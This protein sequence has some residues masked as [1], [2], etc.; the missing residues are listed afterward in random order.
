MSY[1]QIYKHPYIP[2]LL[3]LSF[4]AVSSTYSVNGD[5]KTIDEHGVLHEF[6]PIVLDTIKDA[7]RII[8]S[9]LA[10][11]ARSLAPFEKDVPYTLKEKMTLLNLATWSEENVKN[12]EKI[13]LNEQLRQAL[14]AE[15]SFFQRVFEKNR[16]KGVLNYSNHFLNHLIRRGEAELFFDVCDA[17]SIEPQES[18]VLVAVQEGNLK[19]AE[20]SLNRVIQKMKYHERKDY[21]MKLY[22]EAICRGNLKDLFP[23]FENVDL[24]EI[25]P[26]SI[27]F[28]VDLLKFASRLNKREAV[29]FLIDKVKDHEVG[30]R[31][32]I[33]LG[34]RSSPF[35]L[36]YLFEHTEEKYLE[37]EVLPSIKLGSFKT[38]ALEETNTSI[39]RLD[40][41]LNEEIKTG[42]SIKSVNDR[43]KELLQK[44]EK[45]EGSLGDH[46]KILELF[47]ASKEWKKL[48]PWM[49]HKRKALLEK[50]KAKTNFERNDSIHDFLSD[51]LYQAVRI[52][53]FETVR[54]CLLSL[55]TY[56]LL[57]SSTYNTYKMDIRENDFI[58]QNEKAIKLA[59]DHGKRDIMQLFMK[60]MDELLA[61]NSSYFP[62]YLSIHSF[63]WSASRKG[64][65]E[66]IEDLIK[67]LH[68]SEVESALTS[69]LK[70]AATA[71]QSKTVKFLHEK[72][73]DLHDHFAPSKLEI[74]EVS[75]NQKLTTLDLACIAGN[76]ELYDFLKS[77]GVGHHLLFF[78]KLG[79]L[80]KAG[81]AYLMK[82]LLE[83]NTSDK[84]NTIDN[85]LM[86][87]KKTALALAVEKGHFNVVKLLIKHGADPTN[88]P[89]EIK[90]N[91][92]FILAAGQENADPMNYPQEIKANAPFVLAADQE[93]LKILRFL[94]SSSK[95]EIDIS[96]VQEAMKRSIMHNR[97]PNL[98]FLYQKFQDRI[99]PNSL[100]ELLITS[101]AYTT[102]LSI[103]NFLIKQG[104]NV[105]ILDK[106][107]N[108][109]LHIAIQG[110][111]KRPTDGR[112]LRKAAILAYLLARGLNI[113]DQNEAK[114]TPLQIAYHKFRYC[115]IDNRIVIALLLQAGADSKKLLADSVVDEKDAENAS[116]LLEKF[117]FKKSEKID[118]IGLP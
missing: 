113:E 42:G 63:L 71:G 110:D 84:K 104:A 80:A 105:K 88:Y 61:K 37:Y 29:R 65:T 49:E 68:T 72:G 107:N 112:E 32:I 53:S 15:F 73:V 95:K 10:E 40:L 23:V 93:N 33:D 115:S 11:S 20:F 7:S 92:P 117:G 89:Q 35:I 30:R 57:S 108:T 58:K 90:A 111:D 4:V 74:L 78:E 59:R 103:I 46:K 94:Y 54:F 36:E 2:P 109:L 18:H 76:R 43:L 77:Q 55:A 83:E 66:I 106:E 22:E 79:F 16:A 14:R 100:S 99:D 27:S 34:K 47:L 13:C 28:L 67:T 6:D 45:K 116:M 1:P 56:N 82:C 19:I 91:V 3:A 81:D 26:F 17:L 21:L 70:Y 5:L 48:Q 9:S 69:S 31:A 101:V 25:K 41:L 98:R 39:S 8:L 75:G 38:I 87:Y 50:E 64:Y 85:I 60:F 12:E 114:E 96:L 24:R 118:R 52:S 62:R 102:N 97:L 86:P 44:K 51:V